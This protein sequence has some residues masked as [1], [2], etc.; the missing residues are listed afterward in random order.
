[1]KKAI[2]CHGVSPSFESNAGNDFPGCS[3]SWLGWLQ[4]KYIIAG[5]NCQNPSFPNSWRPVRTYEDDLNVFT[6]LELDFDT[7]R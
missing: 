3:R 2:I 1:M 7:C 6:R 4:Q 5:V